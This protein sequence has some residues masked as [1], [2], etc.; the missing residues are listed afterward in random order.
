MSEEDREDLIAVDITKEGNLKGTQVAYYRLPETVREFF[1][2][3]EKN[4]NIIGFEYDH[5]WTLGLILESKEGE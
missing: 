4:H 5:D 1:M 3:C 2:L